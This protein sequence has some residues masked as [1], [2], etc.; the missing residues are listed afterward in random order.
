MSSEE[1]PQLELGILNFDSYSPKSGIGRVLF[2]LLGHWGERVKHHPADFVALPLPLLRNFP[3]AAN[4]NGAEVILLPQLTGAEALARTQGVPSLA[5]VHDVGIADFPADSA[6]RNWLSERKVMRSFYGLKHATQLVCVS[7]FCLARLAH[8]LP[9]VAGRA[10]VIPNGVDQRFIQADRSDEARA[11]AK[12]DLEAQLSTKLNGPV[13]VY[14]GSEIARK[15]IN[16]L[17]ENLASLK[18]DYPN[19]TLLKVG[20]AGGAQW[21]DKTLEQ[22]QYH[23]LKLGQDVHILEDI[24]DSVLMNAYLAADVFTTPSLYEGFG[25]PALEAMALGTPVVVTNCGA[26]PEVVGEAGWVVEPHKDAFVKATKEALERGQDY[27]AEAARA[28]VLQFQWQDIAE[29][30]LE[31]LMSLRA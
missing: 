22:L 10:T 25:L 9:E 4:A 13:L 18:D 7:N 20:R 3:V 23:Q 30:Y 27:F 26:L 14:V 2:S 31:L 15:N 24:D 5:I 16:L 1:Q 21:R 29:R 8:H 17:L 28:R 19:I 11:R 6:G 12:T